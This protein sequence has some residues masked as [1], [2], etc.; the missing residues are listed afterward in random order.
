MKYVKSTIAQNFGGPARTL[1]QK[2]SNLSSNKSQISLAKERVLEK[3]TW[4]EDAEKAI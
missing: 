1:L 3:R 2:I 4:S